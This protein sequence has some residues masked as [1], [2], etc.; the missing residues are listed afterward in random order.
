MTATAKVL[1]LSSQLRDE[2]FLHAEQEA[3]AEAVGLIGGLPDGTATLVVPLVNVSRDHKAFLADPFSQYLA[4]KRIEEASLVLLA[5]YHSHP[6]GGATPSSLDAVF[7]QGWECIHVVISTGAHGNG[8][9]AYRADC[10]WVE[11]E[12]NATASCG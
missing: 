12:V 3:P 1:H 2:L 9:R 5:I 10:G 6:D 11:V 4:F 7:A 8:L